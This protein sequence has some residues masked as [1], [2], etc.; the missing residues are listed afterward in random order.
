[1]F[2]A[3]AAKA[4]AAVAIGD[5]D[6]AEQPE[7]VEVKHGAGA[8]RRRRRQRPPAEQRV[9][10]VGVHDVGADRAAPRRRPRPGPGRRASSPRAASLRL[11]SPL[12][13]SSVA[14]TCPRAVSSCGR[15]P[16][17]HAPRP[18]GGDIGCGAAARACSDRRFC[19]RAQ[20]APMAIALLTNYLAPYRVP[21]YQRLAERHGVEVL[22]FGG[23]ERYVPAWFADLDAQLAAAPFPAR[24]LRGAREALGVGRRLRGGDR[25]VRRRGGPARRLPR[26]PAPHR[27]RSCCGPRCGPSRARPRTCYRGRCRATSTATPTRSSPTAST[28]AGSWPRFGGAMTTCSWRRSRSSR[29]CSPAR[30]RRASR[31]AFARH[32]EPARWPAGAVRRTA[33][34]GEGRRG[35]AAGVAAGSRPRWC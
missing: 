30:W 23:G 3:A 16:R 11:T 7:V 15:A 22:C 17:P 24:R 8:R 10:V 18:P 6:R 5:R 4:H 34:A 9:Q 35:A 21:L 2:A 1:M 13:R 12:E 20:L 19:Q 33:G 14:T 25:A 26:R 29:S 28:C 31:A 27:R 32:H